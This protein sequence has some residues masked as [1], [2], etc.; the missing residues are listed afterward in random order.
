MKLERELGAD[1][2]MFTRKVIRSGALSVSDL[3]NGIILS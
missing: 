3:D 1:Y 2:L